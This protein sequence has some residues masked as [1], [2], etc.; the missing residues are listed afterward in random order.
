MHLGITF[1]WPT[2]ALLSLPG[3]GRPQSRNPLLA[4]A[5]LYDMSYVTHAVPSKFLAAFTMVC[6][7]AKK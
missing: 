5:L 7:Y 2:K 4:A 3:S 6:M 1:V